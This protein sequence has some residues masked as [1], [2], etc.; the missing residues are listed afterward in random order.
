MTNSHDDARLSHEPHQPCQGPNVIGISYDAGIAA[1]LR[2][3]ASNRLA[4][5]ILFQPL[6]PFWM[7]L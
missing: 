5:A 6:S 3:T 7:I 2:L 1:T 4:G